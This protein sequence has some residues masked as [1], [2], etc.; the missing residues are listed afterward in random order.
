MVSPDWAISSAPSHSPTLLSLSSLLLSSLDREK[1]MPSLQ[2]K[3]TA[4]A[5]TLFQ[6]LHPIKVESSLSQPDRINQ[7]PGQ[8]QVN[9]QQFSGYVTV[10]EKK[11]RA[12]FYY[13]VEAEGDPDSKPLV[14]WLNGGLFL[15]LLIFC[16]AVIR[17]HI[18]GYKFEHRHV[19]RRPF[20]ARGFHTCRTHARRISPDTFVSEFV[21]ESFSLPTEP[22]FYLS[23]WNLRVF[24]CSF[25]I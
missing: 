6:L 25:L 18:F 10:D 14:L 2:W 8:P 1:A 3:T 20:D 4:L 9:F 21:F 12:L 5:L 22:T 24:F 17:T 13:F 19:R 16:R 23:C 15:Q 11:T 7:L